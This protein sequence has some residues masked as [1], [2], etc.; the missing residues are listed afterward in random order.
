M[1]PRAAVT[2]AFD[3]VAERM[4]AGRYGDAADLMIG[5]V[6]E[7]IATGVRDESDQVMNHPS[8]GRLLDLIEQMGRRL[9]ATAEVS[10]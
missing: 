2:D 3:T 9:D 5:T 7:L 1:P 6:G 8:R 4:A 10:G